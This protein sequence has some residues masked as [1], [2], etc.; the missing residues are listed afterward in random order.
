MNK[1]KFSPVF[2]RTSSPLGPPPCINSSIKNIYSRAEGTADLYWPWAVFL[3]FMQ[4]SG[5]KG[6]DVL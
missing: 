3:K 6:D 2:Y 4:G 1:Q 5:P